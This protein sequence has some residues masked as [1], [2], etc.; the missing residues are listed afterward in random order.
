MSWFDD[1]EEIVSLNKKK[2]E[3]TAR[4]WV[5][6]TPRAQRA[7]DSAI[8][9]AR[10]MKLAFFGAEHLLLGL[11]KLGNGA[12]FN[13][14]RKKGLTLETARAVILKF[15][16][17]PGREESPTHLATTPRLKQVL[18]T[19]K[20][21]ARALDHSYIGTEHLLSGILAESEGVAHK[22]LKSANIDPEAMR[23]EVLRELAPHGIPPTIG[24]EK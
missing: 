13:I 12:H 8:K 7:L 21:E 14:L 3:G 11:L 18:K 6:F 4:D 5:R 1:A 9:E 17:G 22:V 15:Y 16:G 10:A 2:Q 24:E 23:K 19:A 20:R